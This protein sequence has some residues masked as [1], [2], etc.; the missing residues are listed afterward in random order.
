MVEEG[1]DWVVPMLSGNA[2][3]NLGTTFRKIISRAGIDVWPKPFQNCRSSRQ[4]ELVQQYPTY[5]VCAWLGNTPS[6]AHKHYLTM[7]DEHFERAV[8]TGDKLGT[9][10]PALCRKES[11]AKRRESHKLTETASFSE[12]VG[13]LEKAR[14]AKEGLE[15]PTRGL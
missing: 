6:I 11:H 4:T 13:L 3:K 10:T 14:V 1:E 2:D 8:K 9:Q 5:V 7:T 12:V 15:P